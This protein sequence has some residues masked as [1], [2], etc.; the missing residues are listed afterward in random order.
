MKI[1]EDNAKKAKFSKTSVV[2]KVESRGG[3]VNFFFNYPK[4]SKL[5]LADLN[6][7]INLGKGKNVMLECSQPNPVHPIHVG[8]FLVGRLLSAVRE[9]ES[10]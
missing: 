8:H 10:Q 1:A 7:K 4:F 2:S 5:V 3:Y 6:K 9:S